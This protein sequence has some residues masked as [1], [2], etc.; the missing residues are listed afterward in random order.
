MKR[1]LAYLFIIIGFGLVFNFKAQAEYYYCV[2]G[3][4][5]SV[6]NIQK[7][8]ENNKDFIN[9]TPSYYL[10]YK[11]YKNFD[12]YNYVCSGKYNVEVSSAEYKKLLD[13]YEDLKKKL[14][15]YN[16]SEFC[17]K[18]SDY[19]TKTYAYKKGIGKKCNSKKI[20]SYHSEFYSLNDYYITLAIGDGKKN[21]FV[22]PKYIA[23][24]FTDEESKIKT[25]STS[26]T[27]SQNQFNNLLRDFKSLTS[28]NDFYVFAID[29]SEYFYG[30]LDTTK[31]SKKK[32]KG[33][34]YSSKGYRCE[35]KSKITETNKKERI[36]KGNV[37]LDCSNGLKF[38]GK[39]RQYG[40][41]GFGSVKEASSN[42]NIDFYFFYKDRATAIQNI[43]KLRERNSKSK[44]VEVAKKELNQKNNVI[45]GKNLDLTFC[46]TEK[47]SQRQVYDVSSVFLNHSITPVLK[48][49][50]DN[51]DS[52]SAADFIIRLGI[53]NYIICYAPSNPRRYKIFYERSSCEGYP[54]KTY[55]INYNNNNFYYGGTNIANVDTKEP[56]KSNKNNYNWYA[57]A[58][59]PQ[60]DYEF[61]STKVS[62]LKDAW[63][64]ALNKCYEGEA[65]QLGIMANSK[66]Y[67]DK[68][69]DG[70]E[71]EMLASKLIAKQKNQSPLIVKTEIDQKEFKPKQNKDNDPPVIS[72]ASNI[73]VSDKSYTLEGTVKDKSNKIFIEIDGETIQA[74]NGKFSIQRY[75]P[76]DEKV[77]IVAIDQWGNKSKPKIVNI[78]INVDETIVAEKLEPLN[79]SNI[80]IR[81]SN[82]KVALIIG[83][84]N[85][86]ETTKAS[87][88][89]LDAKYFYDYAIKAFGT[90]KQNINLMVNEEATY[91]K[92]NKALKLW[93]KS[94]VRSNQTDLIIFFAGHGLA[95]NDGKELY[96][97]PQDGDPNLLDFTA[98]SRTMLF[99][100]I[101]DLNPKSVTMFLDTCY[102]GV[103]RDEEMLLASA[104]PI[105]IIADE[106]EGIPNNFIIFSASK[107]DQISS[108]L[109]N[110]DHGIFSYYLMKGLEGKADL[111]KDKEITNGELLAYMDQNVSQKASELG[112]QQNPSLAGDPDK[113]L[114]NYR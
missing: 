6:R 57:I 55:K 66:C 95:S 60:I 72:I 68:I 52:I 33:L 7:K 8:F 85:Y 91:V 71:N 47:I 65:K 110:A 97:L 30:N 89:S 42:R 105:R 16:T 67:I 78:K 58:K 28:G 23:K 32:S 53:E 79:P 10:F 106:Q 59:H 48:S 103:S 51:C 102:S 5:S 77:K 45:K 84:E 70:N 64:I 90:K 101:I 104:R 73:T 4:V 9:G 34:V 46:M 40:A 49:N 17:L 39:W 43:F 25:V 12:N 44:K 24:K 3:D 31:F 41:E 61:I 109:E 36:Y 94:K 14:L 63:E 15:T 81:P 75:S 13:L 35:T 38:E 93:L 99:Q 74:K 2:N 22:V 113:V 86:T 19:D 27:P 107:L 20:T 108:G 37:T 111:N 1:L 69:F 54:T 50:A 83:V 112:R 88:A 56:K 98:L 18:K 100:T 80:K 76:I 26:N 21:L 96:L 29:K 87:F 11:G 92:T 114:I 82:N 62:T